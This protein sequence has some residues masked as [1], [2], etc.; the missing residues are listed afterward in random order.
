[1][2]AIAY[3]IAAMLVLVG[4]YLGL[5]GASY[6]PAKVADP[7][8][9]R[10]WR[11]PHGFE[12]VAEQIVLSA[13]DGA[14]CRLHVSREDMVLALANADTREQFVREHHISNAELE[15]LVRTGLER[16]IDDAE[17][18]DALN[19]TLAGVLRGVV[20]NLPLDE[21]LDLLQRLRGL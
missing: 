16:S 6:A 7:C 9:T 5:G 20:G 19:P 17:N 10:S 18:A 14:A 13:V 2:R 15:R 21:L 12:A 3:S 8:V 11:S 4:L 1:M